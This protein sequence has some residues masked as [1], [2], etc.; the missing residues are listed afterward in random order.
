MGGLMS[1]IEG[2]ANENK[3]DASDSDNEEASDCSFAS[4]MEWKISTN[5]CFCMWA[6]RHLKNNFLVTVMNFEIILQY[7]TIQYELDIYSE[8]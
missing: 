6:S 7:D 4:D 2:N 3:A 8:L 1:T 5:N